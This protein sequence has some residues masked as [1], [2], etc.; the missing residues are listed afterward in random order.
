MITLVLVIFGN[1]AVL[2][3]VF[4]K[5]CSV[6]IAASYHLKFKMF[7]P[8][9]FTLLLSPHCSHKLTFLAE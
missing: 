8:S 5:L 6:L 2:L 3:A 4:L 9:V 1:A 7:K